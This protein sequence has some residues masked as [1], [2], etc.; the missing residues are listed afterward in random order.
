MANY[1]LIF[2]GLFLFL[3]QM[4]GYTH[5]SHADEF[6]VSVPITKLATEPVEKTKESA[7]SAKTSKRSDVID[8][9]IP[10]RESKEYKFHLSEG[11]GLSYE[12]ETDGPE[13]FFDFHGEPDGDTTG[14][15]E[16]FKKQTNNSSS[17]KHKATFSGTHG[18]YWKN[19]TALP[20]TIRLSVNGA[21][22]RID[23]E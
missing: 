20:V 19:K 9:E 15:F 11:E 18:W 21:Y 12:W 6:V 16:S 13:L 14:Y 10:A 1:S 3:M 2:F 7:L 23:L 17:G 5:I 4:H 22:T 8:I